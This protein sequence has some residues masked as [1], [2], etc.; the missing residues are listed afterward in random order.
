MLGCIF[1]EI[2]ATIKLTKTKEA[3]PD[4]Q[5]T[6]HHTHQQNAGRFRRNA[7]EGNIH[8]SQTVPRPAR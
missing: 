4:G 2:H 6:D 1:E 7:I 5:E 8:G 3:E